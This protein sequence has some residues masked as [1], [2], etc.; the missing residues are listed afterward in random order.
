MLNVILIS[1]NRWPGCY[2]LSRLAKQA[3]I[4]SRRHQGGPLANVMFYGFCMQQ[5][6]R[7]WDFT[8]SAD[9]ARQHYAGHVHQR[10]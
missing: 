2:V 4:F 6:A 9:S 10:I 8:L 1:R 7:K 3:V 5:P